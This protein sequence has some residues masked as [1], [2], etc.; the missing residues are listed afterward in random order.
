MIGNDCFADSSEEL[1]RAS[2]WR[3]KKCLDADSDNAA[4]CLPKGVDQSAI[5]EKIPF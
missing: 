2:G 1:T 5:C 4:E 3:L